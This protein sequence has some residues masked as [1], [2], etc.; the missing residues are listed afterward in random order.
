MSEYSREVQ[1]ATSLLCSSSGS[2]ELLQLHRKLLQRVDITV[3]EFRFIVQK[4]PRFLLVGGPA[5]GLTVVAQ[6]SLRLCGRYGREESGGCSQEDCP[7]LHLCKFFIYG[8]CRFGKGRKPC[9]FSHDIRS[10]RNFDLLRECTLH[11]LN[12]EQLFLLLLQN[13]PALLPE[14]CLHY[15]KGCGPHG[16]CTFRESCTKVHL[17]QHFVQGDCMFGSKCKRQHAIDQESRRML[18]ERGLSADVIHELPFIYRNIHHLTAAV[19]TDQTDERTEICL[20]FTRNSCRFQNECRRVHFHLP[21][22]WEVFD[23]FTWMDLPHMEDIE[24]DFCDPSKM[25]SC[26]INF[27][28]MTQESQPVRRLSTVSSVTKPP[29]YVLT[30][31]WLWYYKGDHG[32]WVEYGQPDEKQRTTSVTSRTLEE[33]FLCDR[34]AEVKVVKGRREYVVSFTDMYQRNHKHNTKRRICRRPRFVSVAQVQNQKTTLNLVL[35]LSGQTGPGSPDRHD[36]PDTV[37]YLS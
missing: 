33:A 15:N 21:Y 24:Q 31:E 22:K 7:H 20:H 35:G 18:E 17:C 5:A 14:V 2:M 6:T 3:Q 9:K 36:G 16:N 27:V 25:H 11:D 23:G 4:C 12:E 13:D 8:N 37:P 26:G 1:L 32:D 28:T 30:T 29:H 19:A 34:T 10:G